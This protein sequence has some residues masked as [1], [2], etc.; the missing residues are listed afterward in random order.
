M[1]QRSSG[2]TD[3]MVRFAD[4]SMAL[5][6]IDPRTGFAYGLYIVRGLGYPR[7]AEELNRLGVTRPASR[8]C[9][10]VRAV[11]TAVKHGRQSLEASLDAR[12]W[13]ST[14]SEAS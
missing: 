7:T 1:G 10:T 11:R 12:G 13:L 3:A 14:L 4:L 6:E 5:G 2:G 9:W 8:E